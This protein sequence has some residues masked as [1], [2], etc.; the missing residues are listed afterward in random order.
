MRVS[1][2]GDLVLLTVRNS[3]AWRSMPRGPQVPTCS[4]PLR[5][6]G[7]TRE[8]RWPRGSARWTAGIASIRSQ[9]ACRPAMCLWPSGR[10][11]L[12]GGFGGRSG[13]F[14]QRF[15]CLAGTLPILLTLSISAFSYG[16]CTRHVT[17]LS[18][19]VQ[20]VCRKVPALITTFHLHPANSAA[21]WSATAY[22]PANGGSLS[23]S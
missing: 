2:V 16:G 1:N 13:R 17:L 15:F 20:I 12:T 5:A 9:T 23:R 6:D 21:N 8:R 7:P 19:D 4:G 3:H 22:S 10:H 11:N 18:L 14:C